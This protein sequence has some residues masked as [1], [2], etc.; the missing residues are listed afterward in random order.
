MAGD[1]FNYAWWKAQDRLSNLRCP[2]CNHELEVKAHPCFDRQGEHQ[3]GCMCKHCFLK[4]YIRIESDKLAEMFAKKSNGAA[5]SA[6]KTLFIN[7]V[8]YMTNIYMSCIL[9]DKID[10]AAMSF[11]ARSHQDWEYDRVPYIKKLP[12]PPQFES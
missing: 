12:E 7:N 3:L 4:L 10:F 5:I 1:N 6:V 8:R 2:I 9:D 11:R